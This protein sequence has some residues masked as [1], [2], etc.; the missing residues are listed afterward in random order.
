M[1]VVEVHPEWCPNGHRLVAGNVTKG[2]L[3][4]LCVDGR[5]GH[6]TLFCWTCRETVYLPP[7]TP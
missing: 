6:R 2:W 5:T 4:C 7:H 3:P 1:A